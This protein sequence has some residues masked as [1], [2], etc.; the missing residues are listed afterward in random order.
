MTAKSAVARYHC[1]AQK[2]PIYHASSI[3][4]P[5]WHKKKIKEEGLPKLMI[6]FL[7][8]LV[9]RTWCNFHYRRHSFFSRSFTNAFSHFLNTVRHFTQQ[10]ESLAIWQRHSNSVAYWELI[11]LVSSHLLHGNS[12]NIW[13]QTRFLTIWWAISIGIGSWRLGML[14]GAWEP[15]ILSII[16]CSRNMVTTFKILNQ[17][18]AFN[19]MNGYHSAFTVWIPN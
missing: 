15:S 8:I 14:M 18:S 6:Q 19:Q 4:F 10:L 12:T 7:Q 17:W 13:K 1:E 2:R 11:S 9:N 3:I 16:L 5:T